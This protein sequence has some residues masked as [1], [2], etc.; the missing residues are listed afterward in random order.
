MSLNPA[1]ARPTAAA[2]LN[3][4]PAVTLFFWLIKILATTVGETAADGLNTHFSLG[5]SGTSLIVGLLLA[6][7]LV[8]QFRARRYVPAV[9]WAAVVWL[10]VFGTL[11]TDKLVDN[12]GVSLQTTSAVFSLALAT[13]FVAWFAVERSLSIDTI[14]TSRREA[15][16][17]LAILFTFALGTAAGDLLAEGLQLGYASSALIYGGLIAVVTVAHLQFQANAVASFWVA[18]VLT[19][20]F[21]ASCG[22]Y[23]SQPAANGGLGLGTV[24]T[25]VLFLTVILALVGWMSWSERQARVPAL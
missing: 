12:F 19:R 5:L 16:Y 23:L 2:M 10:S 8:A 15:F 18:Y 24:G 9:Y 3:K 1:V 11:I 13:T 22:D 6:V 21:G 17:W 20:P 25:S 4:V 7:T 14:V